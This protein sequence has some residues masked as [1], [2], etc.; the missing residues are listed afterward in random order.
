M[1]RLLQAFVNQNP[2]APL[3]SKVLKDFQ[4]IK[5]LKALLE[6]A[7][8]IIDAFSFWSSSTAAVSLAQ[9]ES[10]ETYRGRAR[11]RLEVKRYGKALKH[12]QNHELV[13][14]EGHVVPKSFIGLDAMTTQFVDVGIS[15]MARCEVTLC[16][17]ARCEE[18]RRDMERCEVHKRLEA[19]LRREEVKQQL[20]SFSLIPITE[21]WFTA[22]LSVSSHISIE[23]GLPYEVSDDLLDGVLE[24]MQ[25]DKI[26]QIKPPIISARF[27][28]EPSAELLIELR[29]AMSGMAD[30]LLK[31]DGMAFTINLAGV[32]GS[33]GSGQ[34]PAITS[35]PPDFTESY[36]QPTGAFQVNAGVRFRTRAV[37]KMQLCLFATICGGITIDYDHDAMVGADAALTHTAA[38][39]ARNSMGTGTTLY[40]DY[41]ASDLQTYNS[42]VHDP[43]NSIVATVGF[44]YYV[45]LPKVVVYPEVNAMSCGKAITVWYDSLRDKTFAV[46]ANDQLKAK[47]TQAEQH[48]EYKHWLTTSDVPFFVRDTR[49]MAWATSF[50]SQ[51]SPCLEDHP[52][53]I[54]L[55]PATICPPPSPPALP[56]PPSPPPR[57]QLESGADVWLS[58]IH[59][60]RW[61]SCSSTS[62][63]ASSTNCPNSTLR[64]LSTA[65][66]DSCYYERFRIYRDSGT[67]AIS[68][69]DEVF[70]KHVKDQWFGCSTT[71]CDR[72]RTCP[73]TRRTSSRCSGERFAIYNGDNSG[74]IYASDVV[75]A[76]TFIFLKHVHTGGWL[77]CTTGGCEVTSSCPNDV[78]QRASSTSCP[79]ETFG[80][81]APSPPPAIV[82][83]DIVWLQ[84]DSNRR[85]LSCDNSGC[86]ASKSCPDDPTRRTYA[87]GGCFGER[88]M[89][90]SSANSGALTYGDSVYLEHVALDWLQCSATRC[91]A[92]ATCPSSPAMRATGS[93]N[94][95]HFKIY[96]TYGMGP[97]YQG[98]VVWLQRAD[99]DLWL[100]CSTSVCRTSASCP[101]SLK[102]RY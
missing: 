83:G 89:I 5:T 34:A 31:A 48:V 46:I 4:P 22:S 54:Y 32:P 65:V 69:G 52:G 72:S 25:I 17:V 55:F 71:S 12:F 20:V 50:G 64:R 27:V 68:N 94:G 9:E 101:G 84:K 7:K 66:D 75:Y 60:G 30:L 78:L 95:E 35:K 53:R 82:S 45:T 74:P 102:N 2:L 41:S 37:A 29:A 36:L 16:E 61:L 28:F 85:W 98:D 56:P 43:L 88:F 38:P 80:I 73:A 76:D 15:E 40:C 3:I 26:V 6:D 92:N 23:A 18:V 8:D 14:L 21:L 57:L 44:W 81:F 90:Y 19:F 99:D 11:E 67:G 62:C 93:C 79:G 97:I 77:R 10:E 51:A 47:Q 13:S 39:N 49:L 63:S 59:S 91:D 1:K 87:N 100:Q 42:L 70:L 86:T 24:K 96:N 33:V 58:V